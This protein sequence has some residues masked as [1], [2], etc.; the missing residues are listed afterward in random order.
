VAITTFNQPDLLTSLDALVGGD[1]GTVRR[2][3]IDIQVGQPVVVYVERY[4]D[5]AAI[6]VVR[7]LS[8]PGSVEIREVSDGETGRAR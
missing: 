5:R 3:V 2:A 7:A 6:D 1:I 8:N 4:G